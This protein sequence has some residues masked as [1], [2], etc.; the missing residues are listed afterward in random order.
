MRGAGSM[1]FGGFFKGKF[2][3]AIDKTESAVYI[4]VL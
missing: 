4:I 1:V 3:E 2:T